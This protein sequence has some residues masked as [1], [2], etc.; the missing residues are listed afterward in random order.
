MLGWE[1]VDNIENFIVL[2]FSFITRERVCILCFH[3]SLNL[4]ECASCVC[5]GASKYR[6]KRSFVHKEVIGESEHVFVSEQL[7]LSL[8][9]CKFD[10]KI[11]SQFLCAQ[12]VVELLST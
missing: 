1:Q 6:K 2:F 5:T 10:P 11:F 9:A 3:L 12:L 8:Y 4:H 7:N